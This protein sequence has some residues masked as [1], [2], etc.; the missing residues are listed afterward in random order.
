[1]KNDKTT[2]NIVNNCNIHKNPNERIW[3]KLW[4]FDSKT[5]EIRKKSRGFKFQLFS[6]YFRNIHRRITHN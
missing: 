6:I 5:N 3:F 1:M 2:F 4:E